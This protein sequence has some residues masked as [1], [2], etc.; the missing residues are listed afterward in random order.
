MKFD[1]CL[2]NPP[3]DKNLHIKFLSKASE[4]SEKVVSIQPLTWLEDIYASENKNSNFNKLL[5]IGISEIESVGLLSDIFITEGNATYN[6]GII[7]VDKQ[8][9]IDLFTILNDY[10]T[11]YP[12][13]PID[14]ETI[15]EVK[16][17]MI[18]YCKNGKSVED[19]IKSGEITAKSKYCVVIPKLVG[20]PGEKCDRLFWETSKR[21]GRVFYKGISEGKPVSE[22]KKKLSNVQN[23]TNFDYLEFNTKT[24]VNN[25]I[26]SQKTNFN[27][28]VMIINSVD[29]NRHCKFVPFMDYSKNWTDTEFYKYFNISKDCQDRI[30]N[31]IKLFDEHFKRK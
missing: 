14:S 25:W 3:Y 10:I 22:Y 6:V 2:M 11:L 13:Q 28:F 16:E 21:W 29:A 9:N 24:E 31:Y 8:K 17:K 18:Q 5:N 20:N 23:Y 7:T 15:T 12:G 1:I 4:I 30:C 27:R 26:D 19:H